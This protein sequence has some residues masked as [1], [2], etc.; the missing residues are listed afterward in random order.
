MMP[1]VS[2][3]TIVE[4][5]RALRDY[6][7]S[8]SDS[9]EPPDYKEE[10]YAVGFPD[11]FVEHAGHYNAYDWKWQDI[12][13]DLRNGKFFFYRHTYSSPVPIIP[14]R[15]LSEE[16]A[17]KL[18]EDF[19]H[20]L[21]AFASSLPQG[22]DVLRSLQLDGFDVDR[23]TLKLIALEGPV[24]EQEE[25]DRLTALVGDSGIPE[26]STI[27][28]HIKDAQSLYTEG[29]YHA[30]LNEARNLIQ[31][32][33]DGVSVETDKN[34]Q[35]KTKLPGGSANRI[36]Y[37]KELGFLI[38]DEHSSFRAVWA[39]LS[40]GSHPGVPEREQARIGLI[41]ALELGQLLLFKFASWKASA[42]KRF[43]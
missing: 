13:I 34:G 20:K 23:N 11:W 18:G 19:I 43:S 24:S 15:Y 35:H 31:A 29:K 41:L 8:S 9:E 36:D 22:E 1:R 6:G 4:M 3:R 33:I 32:L 21:A 14:D 28:Q 27:L 37:L 38:G 42:Y 40:A 2:Q 16:N 25:E 30:S 17:K 12:L 5:M 10:L 26:A 7:T 39:T